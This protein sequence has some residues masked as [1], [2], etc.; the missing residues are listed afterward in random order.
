MV[1][2]DALAESKFCDFDHCF[3]VHSTFD[4]HLYNE[5]L[6]YYMCVIQIVGTKSMVFE[7][8]VLSHMHSWSG[9]ANLFFII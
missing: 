1:E 9:T 7:D 6:C 8:T 4:F 3:T 2:I 5:L